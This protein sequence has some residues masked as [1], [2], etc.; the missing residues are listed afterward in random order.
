[1][2]SVAQLIS[3]L[4]SG[5]V[6]VIDLTRPLGPSTPVIALPEMFAQSPGLRS[7]RSAGTTMPALRG[8]GTRYVW[9][10]T[11]GPTSMHPYTG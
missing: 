11:P 6:R 9:A 3:D 4:A 5:A 10:N 7:T 1:M 8:T 2:S